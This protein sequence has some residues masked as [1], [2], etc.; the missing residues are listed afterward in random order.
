MIGIQEKRGVEIL[1][2]NLNPV[3]YAALTG[4]V[5]YYTSLTLNVN[6]VNSSPTPAA[7]GHTIAYR[8]DPIQPLEADVANPDAL[9]T[10][11]KSVPT[12]QAPNLLP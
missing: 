5:S 1:R 8:P 6:L 3:Q 4:E 12:S 9:A 2:V 7:D 11:A 10:Y